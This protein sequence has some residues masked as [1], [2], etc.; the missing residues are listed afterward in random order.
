MCFLETNFDFLSQYQ[1]TLPV[2]ILKNVGVSVDNW[3]ES[4]EKKYL[5]VAILSQ[6]KE[7]IILL[8]E[9]SMTFLNKAIHQ[10]D[11]EMFH[12]SSRCFTCKQHAFVS[13]HL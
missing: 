8:F 4:K 11:F 9:M 3:S 13:V 5:Y 2:V 12:A 7:V 1:L 10:I 6:K